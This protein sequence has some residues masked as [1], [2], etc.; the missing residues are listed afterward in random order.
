MVRRH[1]RSALRRGARAATLVTATFVACSL[2]TG[3]CSR[4]AGQGSI[5]PLDEAASSDQSSTTDRSPRDRSPSG[6]VDVP[7]TTTPTGAADPDTDA[8]AELDELLTRFDRAIS[9]LYAE[10][11]AAGADDHPLSEAWLRVVV[12]G[13]ELDRQVRGRILASGTDDGM[14][15]VADDEGI[16]F[17]NVAS[18]LTV[19]PDGSLEWLNCGYSPGVGVDIR[20]GEVRD[21]NRTSTRGRGRAVRGADGRLL[22]SELWDDETRLLEDNEPDPC[23]S[24]VVRS[25]AGT[26]TGGAGEPTE[27]RA[28]R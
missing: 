15:I 4:S 18:E 27:G 20:T 21:D 22:I 17:S 9:E 2:V 24:L 14:R 16:S 23:R 13:S 12:A 6:S 19:N 1:R 10:P 5:E 25:P 3:A 28:P 8:A 11:L 7:G 26:T